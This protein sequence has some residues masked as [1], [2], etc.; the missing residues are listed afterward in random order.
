MRAGK[1]QNFMP[2]YAF[3]ILVELSDPPLECA[4]ARVKHSLVHTVVTPNPCAR[5]KKIKR[6]ARFL[7]PVFSILFV[8]AQTHQLTLIKGLL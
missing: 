1:W 7:D 3:E 4:C 5:N 8:S 6:Q 2:E